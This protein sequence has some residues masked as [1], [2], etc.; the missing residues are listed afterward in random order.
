MVR[1]SLGERPVLPG[2]PAILSA[3][4]DLSHEGHPTFA[5]PKTAASGPRREA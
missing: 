5:M 3:K 4:E 1:L 2:S